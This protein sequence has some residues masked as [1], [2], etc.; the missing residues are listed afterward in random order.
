MTKTLSDKIAEIIDDF[1]ENV[2]ELSEII[3]LGK[4]TGC[5][6]ITIKMEENDCEVRYV[7]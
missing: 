1:E 7:G 3:L 6:R 2:D 5:T 4:N